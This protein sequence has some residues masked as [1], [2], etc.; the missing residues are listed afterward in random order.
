MNRTLFP[1]AAGLLLAAAFWPGLAQAQGRPALNDTGM[2]QCLTPQ[3]KFS[4]DCTGTGQ[5]GEFGRDVTQP[6]PRDGERG[7]SFAKVC[8]SGE[9]AGQGACPTDPAPGPGANDWGCTLDRVTR[10]TWELKTDDGG[11]ADADREFTN[12]GSG[13]FNDAPSYP[14]QVNATGLCGANDWRLPSLVELQSL[15]NHRAAAAGGGLAIEA[16]AFPNV[17][18]LPHW[19]AEVLSYDPRYAFRVDY[20][21][22]G[23][24]FAGRSAPLPVMLVRGAAL[25]TAGRYA[26]QGDEVLDRATGLV[27][28][29]CAVGQAL[30]A[31]ACAGTATTLDWAG[32]LAAARALAL[33]TGQ[34]WRLPNIKELG[35]LMDLRVYGPALDRGA[36]PWPAAL[37]LWSSTPAAQWAPN[38]WVQDTLYGSS[39]VTDRG[40]ATASVLLVRPAR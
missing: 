27:W 21:A 14:A 39:Y 33:A 13:D 11:P 36:F 15:V 6:N 35:S 29:R 38:M 31:G 2:R 24:G 9:L 37:G 26:V 7:F 25:P 34:A 1:L 28:Q 22:G 20:M 32:G 17:R 8:H 16:R 5:D 12:Q 19:A 10:L 18:G 40:Q 4:L 23:V 3:G 30:V